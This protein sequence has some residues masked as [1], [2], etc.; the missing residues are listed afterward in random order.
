VTPVVSTPDQLTLGRH[1]DLEGRENRPYV[2]WVLLTLLGVFVLLGLLNVFGQKP[3]THTA[4]A[5]GAELEVYSPQRLRSGLF[6]MSRFTIRAREEIEAAT[7]VLDPGWLEGITLNSL[8]PSPVG[9]ANR[10]GKIA[11]DLGRVPAGTKHVFFLH[12]QV[13]PT[14]VGRRSQDVELHDGETRLLHIDRTVTIFP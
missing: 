7:I 1:R 14:E 9:E 2:R 3:H 4:S 13:N 11:L 10:D 6:F 5:G 8:V 12:F